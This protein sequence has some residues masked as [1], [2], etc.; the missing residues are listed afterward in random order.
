VVGVLGEDI[1]PKIAE[2]GVKAS[3]REGRRIVRR[4]A[5]LIA[6]HLDKMESELGG[7]K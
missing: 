5:K 7:P 6:A 2:G 4:M 3:E 1:I